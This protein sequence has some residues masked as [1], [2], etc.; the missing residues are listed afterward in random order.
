MPYAFDTKEK[1]RD[2]CMVDVSIIVLADFMLFLD[3]L[4]SIKVERYLILLS[5]V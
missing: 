1:E 5:K 4:C 3:C 2:I